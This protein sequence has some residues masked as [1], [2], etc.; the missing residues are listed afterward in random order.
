MYKYLTVTV[1]IILLVGCTMQNKEEIDDK[2][3]NIET[4]LEIN[5]DASIVDKI[6]IRTTMTENH[7]SVKVFTQRN[8]IEDLIN[9]LNNLKGKGI[10]DDQSKGWQYWIIIDGY[11]INIMG[12]TFMLNNDVYEIDALFYMRI[13]EIYENSVEEAKKYP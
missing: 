10:V 3:L 9:E 5:I 13:R 1:L 11:D 12:S 7:P 8:E 6:V 2:D 4:Q